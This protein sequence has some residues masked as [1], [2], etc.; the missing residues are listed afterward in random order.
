MTYVNKYFFSAHQYQIFENY[1]YSNLTFPIL[2]CLSS[3]FLNNHTSLNQF[4][5]FRR[6]KNIQLIF[7]NV[8]QNLESF[9]LLSTL[10][11]HLCI[12]RFQIR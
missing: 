9:C 4:Y 2:I 6:I 10:T 5:L 11:D 3:T 1:F 7:R 12:M 8:F